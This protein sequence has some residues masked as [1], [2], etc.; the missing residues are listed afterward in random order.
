MK[1]QLEKASIERHDVVGVV[2]YAWQRSFARVTSNRKA[3]ASRG[4][5]PLTYNLLDDTELRRD[6]SNNPIK[7]AYELCMIAGRTAADPLL[8]NFEDGFS[9]TMMDNK[10]VGYKVRQQ[11]LDRSR[12]ENTAEINQQR[13]E[14]FQKCST[15][16]AGIYFNSSTYALVMQASGTEW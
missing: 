9:G 13:K 5:A 7:H 2:H 15:M 10:V 8:L 16:T 1:M 14:K 6:K 12:A 4:W 11:A 3:T